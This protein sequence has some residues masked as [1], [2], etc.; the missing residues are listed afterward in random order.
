MLKV[1][2]DTLAIYTSRYALDLATLAQAR[3]IDPEKYYTGL[4][5]RT[6]SVPPPGEDIV[7]M[8]ANAAHQTLRDTDLNDIEM[9]I[10]ATESSIDQSKAAGLYVH[11]LLKL[12]ARCRIIE[13]KQ[14][15]YSATAGIQLILPYL[16]QHPRK[17]ALLI[18][19]DIAR[20]GLGTA[21]ESSQGC[22]AV[23]MVLA[24]NPR[25]LAFDHEYGIVAESVMDFWRPSYLKEALV[26]GKYSSK[27]YL[28]MLEKSWTQYQMLSNRGIAD[29][30]Y[31]CYHTPVPRLVEKAHQHLLKI[32]NDNKN[33]ADENWMDQ[34]ECTLAYGRLIGNSYTASLYV[35]LACLL[36]NVQEALANKRIGLYSYG[37]GCV[38]EY[39]SGV[40]QPGYQATLNTAYHTNLFANR[41]LLT[42][43]E[44]KSFYQFSYVEDGSQQIIPPYETGLF[45]LA[46]LEQHK[47]IYE[48]VNKK[49]PVFSLSPIL[50]F[51]T[52]IT[53]V[54]PPTK[55]VGGE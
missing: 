33:I 9:L 49:A 30:S 42:Y 38:A 45:R 22:G 16:R 6:M 41:I 17:K 15:C 24:A 47:R 50:Q 5:Q 20:Y 13:I 52:A 2:I 28:A 34:L 11:H 7:T 44:Y 10:F 14:A 46:Q 37:S 21:G 48:P 35:S 26:E 39:F 51:P 31:Y 18:A 19:A 3:K 4:G 8:A 32:N 40:I 43:E 53:E 1:G 36:D 54:T 23:A 55:N 29:H 12:P 25:I 27:L